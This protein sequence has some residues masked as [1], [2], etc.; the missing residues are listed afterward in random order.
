MNGTTRYDIDYV[1]GYTGPPSI[2]VDEE[3]P[4]IGPGVPVA[5]EPP[6]QAT[7]VTHW[8]GLPVLPP[9]QRSYST[10]L[11]G[12]TALANAPR[13]SATPSPEEQYMRRML[14]NIPIAQAEKAIDT[15][16]KFQGVRIYQ[17]ELAKGKSAT[18]AMTAAGPMLFGSKGAFGQGAMTPYQMESILM[19]RREFEERQKQAAA[20]ATPGNLHTKTEGGRTFYW[21]GGEWKALGESQRSTTDPFALAEFKSVTKR[22]DELKTKISKGTSISPAEDQAEL[23]ALQR[24]HDELAPAIAS[25]PP[26]MTVGQQ[27]PGAIRAGGV[28]IGGPAVQA[29]EESIPYGPA[30]V[31]ALSP[32]VS[33]PSQL[34]KLDAETA[35]E[36]L[37][38]ANGNKAEARRLAR[39][40]GYAF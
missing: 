29:P 6:V 5:E 40:A 19:R 33:A 21:S 12:M 38:R 7:N 17:Q 13:T 30:T 8:G 1:P 31:A 2:T 16:L 20:R 27:A 32:G 18:E 14:E 39:E 28:T 25:K 11:P 26:P 36:F 4:P 22:I 23:A 34:K 35:R 37:R 24:R 15:M 9:E 3:S 10:V